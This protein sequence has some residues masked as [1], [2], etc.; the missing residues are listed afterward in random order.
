MITWDK[1]EKLEFIF[2][3]LAKLTPKVILYITTDLWKRNV[4]WHYM[5]NDDNAE[6]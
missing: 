3:I 6:N 4:D 5:L 2:V 1:L